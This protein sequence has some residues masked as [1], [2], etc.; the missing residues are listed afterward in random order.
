MTN[1]ATTQKIEI[2]GIEI[3]K[4]EQYKYLGQTI[5]F[6]DRTANGVQISIQAGCAVFGKYKEILQNKDIPNCLKRRVSNQC[7]IPT[8]TYGCQTWTK[9]VQNGK[10]EMEREEDDMMISNIGKGQLGLEQR[11]IDSS[12]ES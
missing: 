4:V 12:G 8:M 5:A 7:I 2:E 10:S 3:E 9:D 6:E 1:F 11:E